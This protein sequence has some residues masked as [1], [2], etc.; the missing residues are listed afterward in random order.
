MHATNLHQK[1]FEF[2]KTF[3]D[4]DSK[5]KMTL[6]DT[7][8]FAVFVKLKIRVHLYLKVKIEFRF[9]FI[10][11]IHKLFFIDVNIRL[12]HPVFQK[13]FFN[14]LLFIISFNF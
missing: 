9:L 8:F 1:P 11:Q 7:P 5:S 6:S 10:F 4:D 13:H 14:Y 12:I 3:G 2:T